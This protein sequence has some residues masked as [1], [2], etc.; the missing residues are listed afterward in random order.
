MLCWQALS[1]GPGRL[2]SARRSPL[3]PRI[4]R[5]CRRRVHRA[6]ARPAR[7]ARPALSMSH[8]PS[9]CPVTAIADDA[10]GEVGH[11]LGRASRKVLAVSVQVRAM[12]CSTPR[13]GQ[14]LI[15]VG[16]RGHGNLFAAEVEGDRLDDRR[17]RHRC[18]SGCR[19]SWQAPAMRDRPPLSPIEHVQARRSMVNVDRRAELAGSVRS[20]STSTMRA[21][22]KIDGDMGLVAEPLV[23]RRPSP[24]PRRLQRRT[25]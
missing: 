19:A 5:R 11:L 6:T 16:D 22:G 15:G 21:A 25:A 23:G 18:R 1:A 14:R 12:S 20:C 4:P 17:A 2:D 13:V 7:P 24:E 3:S 10:V 8:V 9:P